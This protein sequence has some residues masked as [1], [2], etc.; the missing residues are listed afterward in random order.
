MGERWLALHQTRP[1]AE[2]HIS[3]LL[4]KL[5]DTLLKGIE[6]G[7]RGG[8]GRVRELWRGG[9]GVGGGAGQR[10]RQQKKKKGYSE[11]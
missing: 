10:E 11:H 2:K 9:G 5:M 3:P 4:L 6:R 8:G 1:A 7:G